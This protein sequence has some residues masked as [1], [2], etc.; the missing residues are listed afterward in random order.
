MNPALIL[1]FS[2]REKGPHR[3]RCALFTVRLSIFDRVDRELGPL[4]LVVFNAGERYRR[5][6]DEPVRK[7][8]LDTYRTTALAGC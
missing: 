3:C 6:T 2:L 4:E 1:P 5:P 8:V 7:K